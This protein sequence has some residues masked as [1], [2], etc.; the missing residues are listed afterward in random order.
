[1]KAATTAREFLD[2]DSWAGDAFVRDV[3]AAAEIVQNTEI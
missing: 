3:H 1:M 2:M